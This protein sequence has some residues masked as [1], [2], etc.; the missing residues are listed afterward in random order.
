MPRILQWQSSNLFLK[1]LFF[2]TTQNGI[3]TIGTLWEKPGQVWH[4]SLRKKDQSEEKRM[5]ETMGDF[6]CLFIMTFV[7]LAWRERSFCLFITKISSIETFLTMTS[8]SISYL[9]ICSLKS[10]MILEVM[11]E[12]KTIE[13]LSYRR[14]DFSFFY[15]NNIDSSINFLAHSHL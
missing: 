7:C 8:H 1:F 12:A 11:E 3:H 2:L 6:H 10:S 5:I 15:T 14:G 9:S 13:D 4:S